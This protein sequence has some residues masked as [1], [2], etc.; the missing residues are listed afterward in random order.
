MQIELKWHTYEPRHYLQCS[1]MEIC[2]LILKNFIPIV[3]LNM[4]LSGDTVH[5]K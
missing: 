4:R 5:S 1:Y 2:D 3:F